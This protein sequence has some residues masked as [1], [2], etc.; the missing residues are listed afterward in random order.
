M[1]YLCSKTY[2]CYDGK[3]DNFKSSSTG[4][5]KR[6]LD[7]IEDLPKSKY[8][9]VLHKAVSLKSTNRRTKTANCLVGT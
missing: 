8:R 7:Y 3:I 9:V 5:N 2:Y 4:L 1:L 6:T